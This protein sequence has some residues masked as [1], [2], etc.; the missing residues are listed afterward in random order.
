MASPWKHKQ[1]N[2]HN[3]LSIRYHTVIKGVSYWCRTEQAV[4]REVAQWAKVLEDL[5]SKLQNPPPKV[6]QA[7]HFFVIPGLPL[8]DGK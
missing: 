7:V 4:G 1:V 6:S 5:S 2:G 3:I 8:R